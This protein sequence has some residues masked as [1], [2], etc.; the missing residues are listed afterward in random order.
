MDKKKN[1]AVNEPCLSGRERDIKTLKAFLGCNL[2]NADAIFTQ[3]EKLDGAKLYKGKIANERFLFRKGTREDAVTLVAHAD[4]V[5]KGGTR[6]DYPSTSSRNQY[7]NGLDFYSKYVLST[8]NPPKSRPINTKQT[9]VSKMVKGQEILA[10]SNRDVGI[11]ADDRAGCAILWL[12]Q[13]SG[14]NLLVLDG[15][16]S[17]CLGARFLMKDHPE[18][19]A[20]IEKSRFCIEFDRHGKEDYKC[21]EIPV[22]DKFKRY[23]LRQI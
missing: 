4:T 16:E 8:Y 22:E 1:S 21:Y 9:I 19:R 3:F 15:E 10:G 6:F 17:G 2:K 5:F 11:G 12:L 14:H 23:R 7:A 18:I 13:N 20:E